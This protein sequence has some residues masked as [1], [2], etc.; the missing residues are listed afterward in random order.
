[1]RLRA[2]GEGPLLVLA[3]GCVAQ[4][5]IAPHYVP[6]PDPLPTTGEGIGTR[7]RKRETRI[8]LINKLLTGAPRRI[9]ICVDTQEA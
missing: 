9:L 6:H 3:I 5:T 1:V 4:R 2:S 8:L 7:A